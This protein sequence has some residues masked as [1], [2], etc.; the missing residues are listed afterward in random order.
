MKYTKP[1]KAIRWL[2]GE[3]SQWGSDQ[4]ADILAFLDSLPDEF[5][6]VE[7][8]NVQVRWPEGLPKET[9]TRL[10]DKISQQLNAW[11][12]WPAQS[13]ALY[14]LAAIAPD[15]KKKRKVGVWKRDGY[16]VPAEVALVPVE[17]TPTFC[18]L[19]WRKVGECEVIE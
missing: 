2:R 6:I 19:G 16:S 15:E 1:H 8:G 17:E 9:L 7:P 11:E 14:A 4:E 10:A 18:S 13:A 12:F 5:E 3:S